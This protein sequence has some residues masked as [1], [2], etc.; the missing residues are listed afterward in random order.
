MEITID[1]VQSYEAAVSLIRE[2]AEIHLRSRGW[3]HTSDTP[4]YCWMWEGEIDGRKFLVH[5]E[6]ALRIQANKEAK[7]RYPDGPPSSRRPYNEDG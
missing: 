4:C 3:K 6:A 5:F 1:S 7:E 2:A